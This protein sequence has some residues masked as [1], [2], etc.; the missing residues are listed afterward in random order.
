VNHHKNLQDAKEHQ[1]RMQAIYDSFLQPDGTL[2][3]PVTES[4]SE[5]LKARAE[6][7]NALPESY[8]QGLL[9]EDVDKINEYLSSLSPEDG[10][11]EA[12][13]AIDAG[14]IQFESA[15]EDEEAE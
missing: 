14:F 13:L 1:E 6:W 2:T 15:E 4:D 3:H 8:K 12:K 11:R 9:L 10:E 5:A 7:F